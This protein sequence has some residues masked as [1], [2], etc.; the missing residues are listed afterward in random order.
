MKEFRIALIGAGET[1]TPLLEQLLAAP[2][3]KMLGVA[4]LD[5]QSPG[6]VLARRHGV[7]VTTDFTELAAIG[8]ELDILIDVTGK[9][10]VRELLR[11]QMIDSGNRHTL[12]MHELISL[13]MLSLSAGK[14]V[15][16]KHVALDY[17]A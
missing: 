7:H 17:H 4:D 14:L 1:G 9:P 13:L 11:K 8:E 6:M 5:E 16:S 10:E 12:I 2:F 3:V 15:E